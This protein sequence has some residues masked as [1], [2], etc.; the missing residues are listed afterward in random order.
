M[1]QVFVNVMPVIKESFVIPVKAV[2]S[3]KKMAT[4]EVSG[5][6]LIYSY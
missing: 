2:I 5:M 3:G 1:G 6:V 4:V